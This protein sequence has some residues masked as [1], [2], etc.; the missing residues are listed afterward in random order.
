[1]LELSSDGS[2]VALGLTG[3]HEVW[4]KPMIPSLGLTPLTVF[5]L[6][7]KRSPVLVVHRRVPRI[8][9]AVDLKL[10]ERGPTS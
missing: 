9:V 1:M 10:S 3:T 7:G 6:V 5:P 4:V 8:W 2:P